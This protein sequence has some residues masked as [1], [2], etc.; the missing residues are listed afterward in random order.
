MT[1]PGDE[2]LRKLAALASYADELD[3]WLA[4]PPEPSRPRALERILERLIQ[5]IVECSAD[6]GDLWLAAHGHPLGE[7]VRGVFRRLREVGAISNDLEDR[8]GNYGRT[9]NLIVH[10]YDQLDAREM[11]AQARQLSVD[12]RTL[13]GALTAS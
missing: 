11:L 13:L 6:A 3:D 9:R 4:N 8:F 10:A 1:P 2:L 5:V 7:S 12:A